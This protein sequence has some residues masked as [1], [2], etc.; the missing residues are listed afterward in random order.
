M[1]AIVE[2]L[3]LDHPILDVRSPGEFAQAHIPGAISFPLFTDEERAQVGICYKQE[4]RDRAVELGFAIA[5]GKFAGFIAQAREIAPDRQVRLHCWRGGM[6]SGALAWVLGM[7]GFEVTTLKG[8]YKAFRHWAMRQNDRSL[9]V[10]TLGGMTG[11]GKTNILAALAAAGEQV[12][13]LE[14]IANH[15][16]SSYGALGLPPQPS[17]EQ[18]EN[19]IAMQWAKFDRDRPVWIEAES[20]GIGRCRIPIGI[21]N[22]MK[23]APILQIVRSRSERLKLLVEMYGTAEIEELVTATDRIRKHLGGLRTQQAIDLLRQKKLAEAFDIVL[24]YY[25][26][27]YQYDLEKRRIFVH[28]IDVTN[29]SDRESALRLIKA[30]QQL[31]ESAIAVS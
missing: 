30:H 6:R 1:T 20:R 22:Q 7:A 28:T 24:D 5:G 17:T 18:F 10:V 23:Q 16:G 27:T 21:F 15:R 19:L 12:L 13:D 31:I 9:S 4:G 29:C 8:G 2:F 11:T 14:A 3:A 26:K 25:D